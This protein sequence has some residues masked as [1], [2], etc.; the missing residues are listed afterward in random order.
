M[1][2]FYYATFDKVAQVFSDKPFLLPNDP[3]AV[4]VLKST[5][6]RDSEF[7]INAEDYELWCLGCYDKMTGEITGEKRK[8]CD[9]HYI[10][11]DENGLEVR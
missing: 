4:K 6:R 1:K 9:A 2:L 7:N 5:Q 11:F 3:S 10:K 8:I